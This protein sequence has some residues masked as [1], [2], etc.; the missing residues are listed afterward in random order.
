MKEDIDMITGIQI[1]CDKC[2]PCGLQITAKFLFGVSIGADNSN[3]IP[4]VT[5]WCPTCDDA[6]KHFLFGIETVRVEPQ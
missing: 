4:T 2:L 6:V 5:T 3:P 1:L